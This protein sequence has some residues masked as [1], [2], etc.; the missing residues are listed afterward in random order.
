MIEVAAEGDGHRNFFDGHF[1]PQGLHEVELVAL[2]VMPRL[3]KTRVLN[4][5]QKVINIDAL[6]TSVG[7]DERLLWE[8]RG[9][10]HEFLV[11]RGLGIATAFSI[12]LCLDCMVLLEPIRK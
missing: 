12:R 11:F 3:G 4:V 10:R 9:L 1:V 5:Q 6:I 2:L 8:S 7:R